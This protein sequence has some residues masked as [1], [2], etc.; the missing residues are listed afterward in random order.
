MANKVDFEIVRDLGGEVEILEQRCD[1]LPKQGEA[2]EVV[3]DGQNVEWFVQSLEPVNKRE[4]RLTRVH[5]R[6]KYSPL[7]AL[8]GS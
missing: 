7:K 5:I 8:I 2:I 4:G 3:V 1:V 6:E